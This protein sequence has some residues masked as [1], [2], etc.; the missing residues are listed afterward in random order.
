MVCSKSSKSTCLREGSDYKP[1][2]SPELGRFGEIASRPRSSAFYKL[3]EVNKM[4]MLNKSDAARDADPSSDSR[5]CKLYRE[6]SGFGPERRLIVA[7]ARAI[8]TALIILLRRQTRAWDTIG[9]A[10]YPSY[11]VYSQFERLPKRHRFTHLLHSSCRGRT[12][13]LTASVGD[14]AV[15]L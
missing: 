12:L 10:V 7:L 6:K 5:R 4:I 13:F 15:S 14:A 3:F 9:S 1:S 8:N 11:E 2:V